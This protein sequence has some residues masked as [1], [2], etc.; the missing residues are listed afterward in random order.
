MTTVD[1]HGTARFVAGR[2]HY[3][4]PPEPGTI[5]GPNTLGE[6]LVVLGQDG[7]ATLIGYATVDDLRA[8]AREATTTGGPRSVAEHQ[9]VHAG[10]MMAAGR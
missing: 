9:I 8:A 4:T 6:H 3:P 10:Q 7:P 5:V 2:A 1:Y